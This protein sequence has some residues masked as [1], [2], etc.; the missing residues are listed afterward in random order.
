M[1]VTVITIPLTKIAIINE[2]ITGNESLNFTS[3]TENTKENENRI[4]SNELKNSLIMKRLEKM[5]KEK[6]SII[7]MR[8]NKIMD[9][10][11]TFWNI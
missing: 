4:K 5:A 1:F 8:N 6:T 9:C 11:S 10:L 7:V 2:R 3:R